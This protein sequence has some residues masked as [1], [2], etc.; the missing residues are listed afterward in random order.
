MQI[1]A[2]EVTAPRR[3][4]ARR[5]PGA[6]GARPAGRGVPAAGGRQVTDPKSGPKPSPQPRPE[7]QRP[8]ASPLTGP[9][10]APVCSLY[11][12][13]PVFLRSISCGSIASPASHIHP[14]A[15][16]AGGCDSRGRV[17]GRDGLR[18]GFC[19]VMVNPNACTDLEAAWREALWAFTGLSRCL[20]SCLLVL[21]LGRERSSQS[22]LLLLLSN[23]N[24]NDGK[25]CQNFHHNCQ[26]PTCTN[27]I[28]P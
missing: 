11:L 19:G 24:E 4:V 14:P 27:Y 23:S 21:L 28:P 9:S 25:K 13:S 22:T 17:S 3:G 1:A 8:A 6:R 18:T 26:K 5:S 15:R 12:T 7:P 10:G 16:V 20:L 2:L